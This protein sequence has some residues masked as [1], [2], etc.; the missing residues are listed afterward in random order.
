MVVARAR[1]YTRLVYFLTSSYNLQREDAR[2]TAN[3]TGLFS[4]YDYSIPYDTHA[5]LHFTSLQHKT[6]TRTHDK[7]DRRHPNLIPTLSSTPSHISFYSILLNTIPK[8]SPDEYP[9]TP[10]SKLPPPIINVQTYPSL[11]HPASTAHPSTNVNHRILDFYVKEIVPV[12]TEGVRVKAGNENGE[13]GR[14]DGNYGS[15]ATRDVE[16]LQALSRRIHF[17]KSP[18]T[19]EFLSCVSCHAEACQ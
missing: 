15:S 10:I 6:Q 14:D 11:L 12:I 8:K 1:R 19:L 7:P 2:S 18:R 16:V 5:T 9:F 4:L 17:G 3:P 13:D